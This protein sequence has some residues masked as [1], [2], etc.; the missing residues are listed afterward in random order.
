MNETGTK[1][2]EQKSEKVKRHTSL[3]NIIGGDIWL[4]TF[5][6][7]RQNYLSLSWFLFCST[8]QPLRL[9][10]TDDRDRQTQKRVD[11]YKIRCSDAQLRI[12]GTKPP[13]AHRRI[14]CNERKRFADF[15]QSAVFNQIGARYE[16]QIRF[17]KSYT[18]I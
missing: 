8:S 14:Y 15:N 17:S 2:E 16:E 13:I 11:R 9:P 5:S 1:Q 12:D 3:K 6:V 7:V 10:A 18:T 4:R